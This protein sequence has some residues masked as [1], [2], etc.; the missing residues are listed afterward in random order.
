VLVVASLARVRP[1][2]IGGIMALPWKYPDKFESQYYSYFDLPDNF[3]S[4]TLTG[5]AVCTIKGTDTIHD[6]R[7]MRE[8]LYVILEIPDLLPKSLQLKHWAP[9]FT[10]NSISN[11][12]PSNDA[13]WAVDRWTVSQP[14]GE[15]DSLR[16]P[17][18]VVGYTVDL[19]VGDSDGFILRVGYVIN[20]LGQLVP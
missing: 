2:E 7:F 16:D 1:T 9:F 4:Y 14:G 8:A 20:L 11:D 17:V 18:T 13:A 5:V 10:L 19:A 12:G 6:G 3:R 15:N